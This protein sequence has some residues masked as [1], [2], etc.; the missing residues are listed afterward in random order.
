MKNA[1]LGEGMVVPK[2][3]EDSWQDTARAAGGGCDDESARSILFTDG[4]GIGIDKP[5]ALQVGFVALGL[6]VVDGSLALQTEGTRENTLVVDAALYGFLHNTPNLAQVVPDFRSFALFHIF[7]ESMSCLLAP[8]HD[9]LHGRERVEVCVFLFVG[10][11]SSF[12]ECSSANTIYCPFVE[13]RA[14]RLQHSE[15]HPIRVEG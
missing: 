3:I 11:G 1:L 6:G 9:F 15:L 2:V 10:G 5:R 12:R 13:E 8:G 7:P 4:K 14:I